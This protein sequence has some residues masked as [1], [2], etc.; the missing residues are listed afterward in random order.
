MDHSFS[1]WKAEGALFEVA[2]KA[3]NTDRNLRYASVAEFKNQWDIARTNY[4]NSIFK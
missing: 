2:L 1:K 3:V 4:L